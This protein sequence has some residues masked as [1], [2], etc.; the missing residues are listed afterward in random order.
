MGL[1]LLFCITRLHLDDSYEE[2]GRGP[3]FP[4]TRGPQPATNDSTVSVADHGSWCGKPI[5]RG[6]KKKGKA[7]QPRPKSSQFY[8]ELSDWPSVLSGE[9]DSAA[10]E[11]GFVLLESTMQT[12]VSSDFNATCTN[13]STLH[14]LN[15]NTSCKSRLD[16]WRMFVD[17]SGSSV[18]WTGFGKGAGCRDQS[19]TKRFPSP[20][21]VD[22]SRSNP[23]EARRYASTP[24]VGLIVI[25]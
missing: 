2:R 7:P 13:D 10:G 8:I 21:V 15:N 18:V 19:S 23:R 22:C 17:G 14:Q 24:G 20:V 3:S 5:P 25:G 1:E 4:A 6:S 16:C 9:G 11:D 12:T